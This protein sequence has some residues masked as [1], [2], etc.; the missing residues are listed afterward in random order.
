MIYFHS[1]HD[2]LAAGRARSGLETT[3]F[4]LATLNVDLGKIAVS[5]FFAI[6][7]FVIPFTLDKKRHN[8]VARFAI[9]RFFRLYPAYWL[10]MLGAIAV[11]YWMAGKNL[12]VPVVLAN[13]TMLQGFVGI[14]HMQGLYWTLQ[15]ELIFYA[16][17]VI[18]FKYSDLRSAK[19]AAFMTVLM[20]GGALGAAG[21]RYLSGKPVPVAIPLALAMMFLGLLWRLYTLERT[22]I[23]RALTPFVVAF[24]VMT[25]PVIASLGYGALGMRYTATYLAAAA[26][27]FVFTTGI[28]LQSRILAWLGM[29]SYSV[30]LC[31]N[32]VQKSLERQV[33]AWAASLDIPVHALIAVAMVITLLIAWLTYTRV[34]LPAIRL[35]K[36][37]VQQ[38]QG[39]AERPAGIPAR[40]DG[41]PAA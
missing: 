33:G 41:P 21:L 28:K 39:L 31:G 25:V 23:A 8:P 14:E 1:A 35:G 37:L 34:E 11:E 38:R 7:G 29:V 20:I 3:L 17:C 22:P 19:V 26:I 10:S 18:I 6:S 40:I 36:S 16:L 30:Y 13:L 4:T 15:I 12:E 5:L 2:A 9:N 24:F 32:L 27:F